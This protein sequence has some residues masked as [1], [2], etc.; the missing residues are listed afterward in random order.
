MPSI[1][2]TSD[3]SPIA[4]EVDDLYLHR[5]IT[6]LHCAPTG[7]S[8]AC[9]VQSVDRENDE[10]Q[11]RIWCF[12]LDGDAPLQLTQGP[13]NDTSPRWSHDGKV[14]AFISSRGGSPQLHVLPERPGD[15][16]QLGSFSTSVSSP[17]W[18]PDGSALFVTASV[19]VD[20]ELRGSDSP[21]P[22][23]ERSATAPEVVWR[24]PYKEDGIGYLLQRQI[25][26]FK[27]ELPGG[28]HRQLTS[29]P[30]DV[31][32]HDVS[33]DGRKIAYS[34][35]QVGRYAHRCDLWVCDG[36]GGGQRQLTHDHAMVMAP[37]W[38]PDGTQIAFTGAEEDG[39]AQPRLWIVDVKTAQVRVAGDVDVADPL[40]LQWSHDGRAIVFV[41]ALR[42]RHH[43]ARIDV[44]T[45]EVVALVQGDHQISAFGVC[46]DDR[47]A[48][49]LDN[50]AMASELYVSGRSAAP[51]KISDF[52]PWWR[53]RTTIKVQSRSF[54]VPDGRGGTERIE[55][56][57]LTGEGHHGAMPLLDDAHGGPAS[58]AL[59][60]FDTNVYW[61]V[62]CSRGWAVLALNAVGSASYGAEFCNRLAGHWGEYDLA[63]HQAAIAQLQ[64]EGVCDERVAIAGKSYG[65]YL[66]AWA[67]GHTELFKAAVVM[68]PVGNIE[69]H[70]G[71]SDGGY[72]ADPFY[73]ASKPRF[74]RKRAMALSPL[75]YIE[76]SRTPTLFLQGKDDERCPKCQ[77]EELFVSLMRAG[78]TPAELVL[79]PE[80]THKFLSEGPPSCRA[81]ATRRI[82][83]WL[84]QH[85]RG[86]GVVVDG[87]QE[88]PHASVGA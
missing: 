33:A 53:E 56:W 79:Y 43:I 81:D 31:L 38:S 36:N 18:A 15:A 21:G 71:T 8:I 7:D 2:P 59:L 75:P 62:L 40:T 54:D 39:D 6:E 66:S 50:P 27:V 37:H 49:T 1:D 70:Y 87:A 11:S 78:D 88:R 23:P 68:A 85:G 16:R 84:E 80:Q 24:L 41:Q 9:S 58:Y 35:T 46:A 5:R 30:Y 48:H 26:L 60:D 51:R 73:V 69:T 29:G 77:S 52:N 74:D 10:D 86:Q 72:Y 44:A 20:P 14:L 3:P 67:T 63:Q 32:A 64:A 57:L 65:G 82:V 47:W 19:Q 25:H 22:A 28:R 12:G 17:R 4:F 83:A 34:R 45:G 76:Q 13:G 42:G 61:Q 55:G